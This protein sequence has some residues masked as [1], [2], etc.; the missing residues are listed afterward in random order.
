[1]EGLHLFLPLVYCYGKKGVKAVGLRLPGS[2]C[3]CFRS[4]FDVFSVQSESRWT[5][6]R[7]QQTHYKTARRLLL[8]LLIN[9]AD[10][11]CAQKKWRAKKAEA[12][13]F[14]FPLARSERNGVGRATDFKNSSDEWRFL[15]SLRRSNRLGTS[16]TSVDSIYRLVGRLAVCTH[17]QHVSAESANQCPSSSGWFIRR[18]GGSLARCSTAARSVNVLFIDEQTHRR[19]L[20]I[21]NRQP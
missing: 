1:M 6:G 7:E 11:V 2:F 12:R 14:I 5:S 18:T 9:G 19:F 4:R 8:S 3:N 20:A 10:A 17:W 15:W 21:I 16:R 13:T